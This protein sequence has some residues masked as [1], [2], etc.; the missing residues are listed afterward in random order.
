MPPETKSLAVYSGG[1]WVAA[2]GGGGGTVDTSNLVTKPEFVDTVQDVN[3]Q[4]NNRYTR[5]QVDEIITDA[6]TKLNA[7]DAR[8][9]ALAQA[10]GAISLNAVAAVRD[11]LAA[12]ASNQ[13]TF[14]TQ[15]DLDQ[16]N[17]L[18][19]GL[20]T[21]TQDCITGLD[22][23]ADKKDLDLFAKKDDASQ[24]VLTKAV[25]TQTIAF[26]DSLAPDIVL[27]PK[28]IDGV[29]RMVF[30]P[31]GR[32]QEI[33]TFQSDAAVAPQD[34]TPY[35]KLSDNT[36]AML[37]GTLVAR[38]IGFGDSSL[39]PVALTY[40]DTNEGFGPRL[41][42]TV[43]LVNDY[44][45]LRSDFEPIRA[46][47]DSLEGKQAPPVDAYTKSQADAKFLTLVDLG[48]VMQ[49]GDGYTTAEVNDLFWRKDISDTRYMLKGEGMSKI[50]FDNQMALFLYTRSQIDAKL[51]AIS[52]VGASTINDPAIADFKKSV[53]DEV[54][55]MLAGGTKMPPPDID[56]TWMVRMDG[57][58]ES[59]STE[60]QARM[61]GGFIELKGTL[62][63]GAGIGEW[64]P[65]RLPPQFPL[66]E[67]ESKFPLAMRLVGT[68][69]TYGFCTIH[70][71]NRDIKVSPGARSSEATFSG[72][73]W[74]VAY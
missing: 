30:S 32:Q 43:G 64:V 13:Q 31:D 53:L 9:D 71:N 55:K 51:V 56:W 68:A 52:P 20:G 58:K 18:L 73:R 7:E 36:Q 44:V 28:L 15:S 72:I 61:I 22:L 10:A 3:A 46:R 16:T 19:Q 47:I 74:K 37:T 59:V 40:V 24:V 60:I 8:L 54:K 42:F 25:I 39:P 66:A 65:L 49:K 48:V 17:Q 2:A 67:L 27:R 4:L 26:G 62:S 34:L 6:V 70:Q 63:F 5:D 1:R 11:E 14:L 21:A 50:D 38:A 45:A 57:A 35:A 41:V 29:I 12:L 69:V 33:L 23:K